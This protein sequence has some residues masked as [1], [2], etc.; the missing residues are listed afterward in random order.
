MSIKSLTSV[1]NLNRKQIEDIFQ[2][3]W[4]IKNGKD[5]SQICKNKILANIFLEPSTRTSSSFFAA[6]CKLGGIVLPIN[7]MASTSMSKKETLQDTIA[8]LE[9]IANVIVLRQTK[10]CEIT[11]SK[12]FVNAGDGDNEH[13]TQAL[14]DAYT[15]YENFGKLD[16]LVICMIGDVKH[17]RTIHSLVLLLNLFHTSIYFVAPNELGGNNP[18]ISLEHAVKIADV[19]YITRIQKERSSYNGSYYHINYDLLKTAKKNVIVLHPLP[20]LGELSTDLD[21]DPRAKYF[22][23]IKNGVFVRMAIFVMMFDEPISKL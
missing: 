17:S 22:Q 16:N 19:L 6:F 15:I 12:P 9:Q 2:L 7:D 14:L 20:R 18:L 10:H 3:T 13:P 11:T 5:V 21:N 23:Q 1:K 8:T 4:E